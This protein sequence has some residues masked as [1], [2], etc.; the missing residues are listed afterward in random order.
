[1]IEYVKKQC[2][3]CMWFKVADM[4]MDGKVHFCSIQKGN[5]YGCMTLE[6]QEDYFGCCPQRIL[7]DEECEYFC[8]N[9][10]MF[11]FEKKCREEVLSKINKEKTNNV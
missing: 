10:K 4:S 6:Y 5:F 7:V 9:S 2:E 1:M 3:K 8:D 11:E